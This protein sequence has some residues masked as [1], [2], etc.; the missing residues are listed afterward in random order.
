MEAVGREPIIFESLR[1]LGGTYFV[2]GNHEISC[3][4]HFPCDDNGF[5]ILKWTSLKICNPKAVTFDA[6]HSRNGELLI[7]LNPDTTIHFLESLE[8]V[9]Q[10]GHKN[11][12]ECLREWHQIY[13][14]PLTMNFDNDALRTFRKDSGMTQVELANAIGASVRTYQKWEKGETVPD[15]HN[16]LRLMNWLQIDSVQHLIKYDL[17]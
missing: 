12:G 4:G 7:A 15:G 10:N 11:N 1:Q 3:R 14:G 5:P 6:D 2:I 8:E 9:E 17:R 16:L 13:A